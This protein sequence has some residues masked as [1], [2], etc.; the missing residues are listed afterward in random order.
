V[1]FIDSIEAW[2]WWVLLGLL[3]AIGELLGA[4]FVLLGLGIGCLGGAAASLFG[5]PLTVQVFSWGLVSAVATPV[6]IRHFRSSHDKQPGILDDGWAV[7]RSGVT[8]EYGGR[9]GLRL[10]GDFYPARYF[11]TE[12]PPAAGVPVEVRE[13]RGITVFVIDKNKE[14]QQ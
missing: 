3:L 12:Q 1:G 10:K 13:M 9:V 11:D 7:G 6:L 2:H 5:A 8:E 4:Q 14:Q